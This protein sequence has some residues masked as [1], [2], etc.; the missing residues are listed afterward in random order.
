MKTSDAILDAAFDIYAE[1]GLDRLSMRAVA[2]RVRLSATAL[3]RHYEDKDALIDAVAERG[4]EIFGRTLRRPALPADPLERV[5]GILDRYRAF[6]LRQPDLF[7]LMFSTPRRRA[8]R[9]PADF[10]AHRSG[11]FDDLRAAVEASQEA[12]LFR[13]ADSLETTLDLW[14]FAHGMLTLNEAGRFGRGE[15]AFTRLYRNSIRRFF[16]GLKP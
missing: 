13:H 16:G 4:F 2:A 8:R 15:A 1:E 5:F 9:F 12:G 3:Y 6:A 7:R 14:A 11:V 10:A